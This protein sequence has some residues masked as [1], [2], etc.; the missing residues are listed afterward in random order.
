MKKLKIVADSTCD[1]PVEIIEEYDISII[2]LN[3]IFGDEV[4]Q[5]YVNITNEEFYTR[6]V[7]GEDVT[8]GVP[9]PSVFKE[10]IEKALEEAEEVIVI[11]LSSKLSGTH[12][13]AKQVVDE[14][15]SDR[16]VVVDTLCGTIQTGLV[17]YETAKKIA[18]GESKEQVL[19][20]LKDTLIPNAHLISYAATLK[21][22]QRSGRISRLSR[23][24][25]TVLRIKPIFH[26]EDGLIVAPGRVM[27]WQSIDDTFKK[28]MHKVAGQHIVET[29]FIA[30]SGNPEK[31]QELIDYF[32]SI[33]NAPKD[34]RM[35]EVG[36]AVGVHVGPDTFGFVWIGN[37][38]EKWFEDL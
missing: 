15:F 3:I 12:Q 19:Q 38:D 11:T 21:Y 28:L 4:R 36:P 10:V 23:Y 31:C 18:E 17:V 2:P 5:Q 14:Y 24:M 8:T 1:L 9:P 35:A 37:Y 7:N 30:H 20:Y 33:P 29:A 22:L 25:G 6:L 32:K 34:I 27:L 26:I 13:T 16:A